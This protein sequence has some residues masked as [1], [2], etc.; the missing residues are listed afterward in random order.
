M[1]TQMIRVQLRQARASSRLASQN[2]A[3]DKD[4]ST[5]ERRSLAPNRE[6][7]FHSLENHC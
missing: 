6:R 2:I 3:N 5:S 1:F 7:D 4:A